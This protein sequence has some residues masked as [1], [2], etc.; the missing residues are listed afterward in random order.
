MVVGI[1]L[2]LAVV[3]VLH[4][5]VI[6]DDGFVVTFDDANF[7]VIVIVNDYIFA[8]VEIDHYVGIVYDVYHS[9]Y[10]YGLLSF[11]FLLLLLLSLFF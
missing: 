11:V 8:A 10:S 9:D 4:L 5:G 6:V 2:H 7:F 1:T 3:V